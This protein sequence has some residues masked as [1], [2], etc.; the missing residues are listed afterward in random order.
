MVSPIYLTVKGIQ[1]ATAAIV[2]GNCN[3]RAHCGAFY[4]NLNNTFSNS[5]WNNGAA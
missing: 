3:N 1:S 2:G 5:N 4:A